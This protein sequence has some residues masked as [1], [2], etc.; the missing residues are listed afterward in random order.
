MP[1]QDRR[2]VTD[3]RP[4][5]LSPEDYAY[6]QRL[7]QASSGNVLGPGAQA[8]TELRLAAL[9][10]R[11]G[12]ANVEELV[13]RV[14]LLGT[15]A[16]QQ[17]VVEAL[18]VHES[19]FFRDRP[20]WDALREQ[21]LPARL[22]ANPGQR[23]R[24]WCAAAAGGQEPW[25]LAMALRRWFLV[26]EGGAEIVATDVSERALAQARA[27]RYTALEVSR[28]LTEPLQQRFFEADDGA[29][30]LTRDLRPLVTFRTLNLCGPWPDFGTFDLVLLRNVLFYFDAGDRREV[31]DRTAATLRP[32]GFLVLG[33]G[34][35][36]T[37]TPRACRPARLGGLTALIREAA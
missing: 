8:T 31:L 2:A 14:R 22:R 21:V 36:A 35:I 26:D 37:H 10:R 32:G 3:G 11:E 28:G 7:L 27:G 24:A 12:Y 6:L 19:S 25:S 30:V 15:S 34:E 23:F 20:V 33:S 18:L 17:A 29:F 16:L 5:P 13:W 4:M 1:Y 9:A